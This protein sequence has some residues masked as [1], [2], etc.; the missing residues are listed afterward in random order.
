MLRSPSLLRGLLLPPTAL[1][2]ACAPAAAK[3]ARPHRVD[4]NGAL[5][6]EIDALRGEVAALRARLDQ[7]QADRARVAVQAT[8]APAQVVEV[9]ARAAAIET[10]VATVETAQAKDRVGPAASRALTDSIA[11][12]GI[13]IV[14]GGF[15]AAEAIGRARNQTSDI[16]TAWNA[17]P[18]GNS[19]NASV[20]E[21]RATA[22]QSRISLLA[23][24][25]AA[26]DVL[27]TGYYE[28]DFQGAART[29]NSNESNSYNPRIRQLYTTIDWQSRG[30]SLLAGQSWS[31]ATLNAKGIS[32]RNEAPPPVIDA[33]Y[34]PGFVWAREPQLRLTWHNGSGLWLAASLEQPQTT[35]YPGAGAGSTVAPVLGG[36]LP[37]GGPTTSLQNPGGSGF[38]PANSF[39]TNK[40]PD[41][42]V[43]AAYEGSLGEG[44]TLHL[45]A[46]GIARNF[47]GLVAGENLDLWRGGVGGGAVVGVLPNGGLD[48]QASALY[49]QGMGRYGTSQL[50]DVTLR[51]D[52]SIAPITTSMILLGAV[53]RPTSALD[54]YLFAGRER[55]E[56]RSFTTSPL[57]VLT[58]FGYGNPLYNNGGCR[59]EGAPAATCIGNT[60]MIRQITGGFWARPYQGSYGR[61]QWGLQYSHT[62][63]FAF[64]G[65]GGAPRTDNDIILT[66][67]RYYPF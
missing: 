49:G 59:T 56:A 6:A 7:Q 4:P 62:D 39:S 66:S 28:M 60:R 50:P 44:R 10:Q 12:K 35:F 29:A 42:I 1:G 47:Y 51:P 34:V 27:L 5:R 55:A 36:A 23:Q 64:E 20:R 8:A 58:A 53:A 24:G 21:F 61:I 3:P 9:A 32:P 31:L 25:N 2:L 13:R 46:F 38:D 33:Q 17:I 11:F 48:L 16:A 26:P 54:L 22:R 57:G 40:Y 30:L 52:G 18:F 45:E 15:V 65:V 67:L 43:K 19:P 41:A 63:R 14:P 37:L